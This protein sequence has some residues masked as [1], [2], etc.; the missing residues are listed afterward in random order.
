MRLSV[1][2]V[3][4]LVV[5]LAVV[6][7][8][9]A[10]LQSGNAAP[11]T[12]FYSTTITNGSGTVSAGTTFAATIVLANA[13]NSSQT[14]GSENVILPLGYT[15]S[16]GALV[17]ASNPARH[18]LP[19]SIGSAT[20]ADGT[21]QVIQL[22]AQSS[23]DALAAGESVSVTL[24]VSTPCQVPLD[25]NWRTE[26]KQSNAFN[27]PPGNDFASTTGTYESST[28]L[29][30]LTPF[31]SSGSGCHFVFDQIT[32]PQQAGK[33]FPVTIEVQDGGGNVQSG[34]AGTATLSSTLGNAP[35][36]PAVPTFTQGSTTSGFPGSVQFG[37]GTATVW[38]TAVDAQ[39][40]A[41]FSI[42]DGTMT[43]TTGP[44]G[45]NNPIDVLPGDPAALT[46]DQQ[47][48]DTQM[49]SATATASNPISP[50]VTVDVYDAYGNFE[51][52]ASC[53]QVGVTLSIL[54]DPNAPATT[55]LGGGS[56]TSV[57]GVAT[58]SNVTL[59]QS[60]LGFTL[61]ASATYSSNSFSSSASTSFNV[62]DSSTC[63]HLTQY[64]T[65]SAQKNG[66]Q[67][68]TDYPTPTSLDT[69]FQ[70]TASGVA[71]NCGGPVQSIGPLME[72]TPAAHDVN[73]TVYTYKNPI[74][75][76]L[77]WDKS[78]VPGTGVSNFTLCLM[79]PNG[80]D[81]GYWQPGVFRTVQNCPA[82]LTANTI[83][84]C[85][86]KASRNNAGDLVIVMLAG[87]GDPVPGVH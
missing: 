76:T 35:K 87:S 25:L 44:A 12:K 13:A 84:P 21:H 56:A 42:S 80:G 20:L 39:S 47:P 2:K 65:C 3:A 71:F 67:I 45:S 29:Y 33:P 50:A 57:A 62:F 16:A 8:G 51:N 10:G 31:T 1:P 36:G 32:T 15:A 49:P 6:A 9:G 28:G 14:L 77:R 19:V 82:K 58:F 23:G 30:R 81:N 38:V 70:M 43:G 26:A 37:G 72:F 4:A 27:G 46:F 63:S 48:T 83:L 5:V 41:T 17:S 66:G 61:Q 73:G 69:T 7:A 53:A 64:S 60:G 40:G 85:V 75:V 79:K 78:L 86:S 18:W 68:T 34:Y 24:N 54:N 59:S 22:R 52:C 55:T 74:T 11:S